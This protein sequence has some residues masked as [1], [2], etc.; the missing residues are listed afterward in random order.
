MKRLPV[1]PGREIEALA[2]KREG[3]RGGKRDP[4]GKR[5]PLD[6]MLD[7][8][9]FWADHAER[10]AEQLDA[11]VVN[12]E[13][14]KVRRAADLVREFIAAKRHAQQCAVEAAPYHHGKV[15][16]IAPPTP[17]RSDTLADALANFPTDP[18][19]AMAAYHAI[20]H[21]RSYVASSPPASPP[22]PASASSSPSPP[23]PQGDPPGMAGGGG[24]SAPSEEHAGPG[25]SDAVLEGALR[26]T[27]TTRRRAS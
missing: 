16:T 22:P 18:H 17:P 11:L 19:E 12:D 10:I 1:I 7:N 13:P 26:R 3:R 4:D 14:D 8:M 9:E 15:H 24:A 5:T 25:R 6:V 23:P 20:I 2:D 21:G 27:S